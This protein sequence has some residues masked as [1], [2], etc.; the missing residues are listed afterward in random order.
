VVKGYNQIPGVD[1]TESF[2][3]V[4]TDTTT[5][6]IFAFVLLKNWVCEI[7]DVEAAFLNADLDEDLFIDYSNGVVDFGFETK[8]TTQDFCILLD[9]AMYGAVQAARQWS[10]KLTEVLTGKLGLTQSQADPCLFYLKRSN[11]LVLIV[12]THVDDQQV[13]G[14]QQDVEEFKMLLSKY[15]TIKALGPVRKHLGVYYEMGKDQVGKYIEA[16]MLDFVMGMF[17]DF[18]EL[19]GRMPKIAAT[20]GQPGTTLETNAADIILQ[21]EYRSIVGKLLYFMKKISP[22]CA[23]AIRELSQHLEN[24]GIEHWL[25]VERVL[26]F[27]RDSRN[28]KLKMRPPVELRVMSACDSDYATRKTDRRS[29]G[30]NLTTVGH[31]LVSWVSKDNLLLR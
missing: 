1:F 25:A 12:G 13:A 17:S 27:L 29:V 9:K 6:L 15:F 26:G 23:N 11:E 14:H 2:S 19:T 3:P 30:G 24:P 22:L 10:K 8:Q 4:A 16:N 18:E 31:S 5:R 7:V 28:C 20:P 21:P